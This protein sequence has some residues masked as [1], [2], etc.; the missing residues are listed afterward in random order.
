[1][2]NLNNFILLLIYIILLVFTTKTNKIKENMTITTKQKIIKCRVQ[3]PKR[4]K[5]Q[6]KG[7][8]LY[9]YKVDCLKKD[10]YCVIPSKSAMINKTVTG[11][12]KQGAYNSVTGFYEFT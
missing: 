1:M 5:P 10:N 9:G 7:N 2:K 12:C 4:L 6:V 11:E 3:M 8:T